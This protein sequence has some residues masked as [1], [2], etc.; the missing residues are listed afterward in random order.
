MH[1]Y[2]LSH[3]AIPNAWATLNLPAVLAGTLASRNVHQPSWAVTLLVSCAG[4][5]AVG[6]LL[7]LLLSIGNAVSKKH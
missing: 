4:W 6:Y 1:E 3:P 2:F 7:S 5:F